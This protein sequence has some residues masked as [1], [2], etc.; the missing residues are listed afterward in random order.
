MWERF[1]FYGMRALLLF[2]MAKGFLRYPDSET[3][4]IYGAYTAL[5]YMSP[6]FGGILADRLLGARRAVIFGGL[7]MAAGQL[8]LTV[9]TTMAFF[10][11]LAL[12]ICGNGFFKPN[13]STIVGSLYAPGS[14]K[15]DGGFTIFYM[16]INLGAAMSPL[17]CGYLGETYDYRLGFGLAAIGMLVG[18]AVF[19]A[20]SLA[21]RVV[22]IS[23]TIACALA[24]VGGS[25]WT[26]LQAHVGQVVRVGHVVLW[27]QQHVEPYWQRYLLVG[28]CLLAAAAAM[29][30][31]RS[32]VPNILVAAGALAGTV[33]MLVFLPENPFSMAINVFVGVSLLAA[34]AVAWVALMRGGLAAGAGAPP[35]RR[36]AGPVRGLPAEWLVYLGIPVAIMIF[37]LLVSGF[38][39]LRE[40][41]RGITVVPSS[42]IENLEARHSAAADVAALVLRESGRP[43]GLVVMLSG[44]VAGA[45]LAFETFRLE[46]I[47]RQR[48]YVVLILMFF[49]MVFFAFFEQAGSSLNNFTDRNVNRVIPQRTVTAA[50]VGRTIALQPTQEQLGYHNGPALF[51]LDMLGKLREEHG[52]NPRFTIDWKVTGDDIGMGIANRSREIPASTFLSVNSV[53]ILI[54]GLLFTAL[55]GFLGDRGLE[56]STTVKFA[57]GL[58]Q[59]GLGFVAFWLGAQMADSRGMVAVG[60]LL[61]GYLLHTTGEL[62]LSPVGLSMV[63]RLSPGRLVSTVMGVWFLATAFSQLL[64]A[65]IAQF[66]SVKEAAGRIPVPAET[67]HLYGDVYGKIAVASVIS[68]LI[69]FALAP[70]LTR[71]MHP[72]IEH[73]A[74]TT[75]SEP[76]A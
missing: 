19:V 55:W 38:S 52:K 7:L 17:L 76:L 46:R 2:Y 42:V 71:W 47:A 13:I 70:L 4:A 36:R 53:Y 9:P 44:L 41:H 26:A 11:S 64:A 65:I 1:S 29:A 48:M 67:V 27:L 12:L 28:L 5:V 22:I 21:A 35:E 25:A 24:S 59:L 68:A 10:T 15:R 56:P 60:W 37:V 34:A 14:P 40:A 49:S 63:T 66:T 58:L 18:I 20:R 33:A 8:L 62:C 6:F 31:F 45:Y 57:L 61:L 54:F 51:T 74:E 3:Y 16:G 32:L 72:E 75:E 23:A 43:A 30:M 39:V 73:G 69:C 50:E